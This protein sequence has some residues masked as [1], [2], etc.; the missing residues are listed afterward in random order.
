MAR[1]EESDT[2]SDSDSV[3]ILTDEDDK[4]INQRLVEY[5]EVS[6]K[7]DDAASL[8]KH[9]IKDDGDLTFAVSCGSIK[10]S[11]ESIEREGSTCTMGVKVSENSGRKTLSSKTKDLE[12]VK[13]E[14][15][16]DKTD[17][18]EDEMFEKHC[19][20]DMNFVVAKFMVKKIIGFQVCDPSLNLPPFEKKLRKLLDQADILK[21]KKSL[22]DGGKTFT[23]KDMNLKKFL[24]KP[25]PPPTS[26]TTTVLDIP[27]PTLSDE[28][29]P[30]TTQTLPVQHANVTQMPVVADDSV[31]DVGNSSNPQK[32]DKESNKPFKFKPYCPPAPKPKKLSD[33]P[34]PPTPLKPPV[35]FRSIKTKSFKIPRAV[36]TKL[37]RWV[38]NASLWQW[39][40][41]VDEAG[42]YSRTEK[43]RKK[44]PCASLVTRRLCEE[45]Q[46]WLVR[47]SFKEGDDCHWGEKEEMEKRDKEEV[48]RK[49]E[50][51][52]W[53]EKVLDKILGGGTQAGGLVSTR[54]PL[55]LDDWDSGIGGSE[56][57]Q[58]S[59]QGTVAGSD[60]TEELT[61]NEL[62][63]SQQS[64][65]THIQTPTH[66]FCMNEA[67]SEGTDCMDEVSE[68]RSV[69]INENIKKVSNLPVRWEDN[70]PTLSSLP[71]LRGPPPVNIVLTA[72]TA[73]P[74][75]LANLEEPQHHSPSPTPSVAPSV[76]FAFTRVAHYTSSV[77]DVSSIKE[78]V[79]TQS[80]PDDYPAC[81][82]GSVFSGLVASKKNRFKLF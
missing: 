78:G 49:R 21:L 5:R 23:P 34:K 25:V 15:A 74:P 20:Q 68:S 70:N 30:N 47:G 37:P 32:T 60:A 16:D 58:H 38:S 9:E 45:F 46:C 8:I 50:E 13:K 36:K 63:V 53:R 1:G 72:P 52:M 39:A 81:T 82:Q 41:T 55:G 56:I 73:L 59:T 29:S 26:T 51:M 48:K 61:E 77:A 65:L 57:G 75:V 67:E 43:E 80:L 71:G 42:Q 3:I 2:D 79:N 24:P 28:G 54:D 44:V 31:K 12:D 35:V 18:D 22:D 69:D 62:N 14:K 33:R 64:L 7:I 66:T 4:P 6:K 27:T 40:L 17:S 10:E 11:E 76:G 19:K